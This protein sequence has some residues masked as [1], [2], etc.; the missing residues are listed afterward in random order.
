M[1]T[2]SPSKKPASE[3]EF[4][5]RQNWIFWRFERIA[6]VCFLRVTWCSNSRVWR[7]NSARFSE[8]PAARAAPRRQPV[9]VGR[10]RAS[11]GFE[12]EP[13]V[14]ALPPQTIVSNLL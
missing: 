9:G 5:L 13:S 11:G 14:P 3:P 2:D 12:F 8:K 4:S 10:R 6:M 7:F 1:L